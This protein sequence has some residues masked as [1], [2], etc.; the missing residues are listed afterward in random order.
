MVQIEAEESIEGSVFCCDDIRGED[1]LIKNPSPSQVSELLAWIKTG[2]SIEEMLTKTENSNPEYRAIIE[3][4][5][6]QALSEEQRPAVT[7][8]EM[9]QWLDQVLAESV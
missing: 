9:N 5:V 2:Q 8:K 3:G 1:Y 4:A 7:S 6:S